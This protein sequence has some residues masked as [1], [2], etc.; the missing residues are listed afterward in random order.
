GMTVKVKILARQH[1][2]DVRVAAAA[3]QIVHTA[4]VLV[5]AVIG[6]AVARY[7]RH[8][9]QKRQRGPQTIERGYMGALQLPRACCPHV[10]ARVMHM[11]QI[12][13]AHLRPLDRDDAEHMA[14]R[15]A[16]GPGAANRDL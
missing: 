10:L 14:R 15:Y 6:Q 7:G 13:V 16:P 4:A 12:E 3:E 8:G 11:P 1:L 5:E 9:P 2:V